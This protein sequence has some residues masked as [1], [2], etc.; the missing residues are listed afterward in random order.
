MFYQCCIYVALNE[1]NDADYRKE[2]SQVIEGEST[3]VAIC[4]ACHSK[5]SECHGDKSAIVTE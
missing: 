1:A 5:Q 3:I 4:G 2:V